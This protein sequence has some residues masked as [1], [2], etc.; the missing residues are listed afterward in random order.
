MK[1]WR[2]ERD[3]LAYAWSLVKRLQGVLNCLPERRLGQLADLR[4]VLEKFHGPVDPKREFGAR[5]V[6]R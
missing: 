2:R 6:R 3:D 5:D 1:Q 4:D